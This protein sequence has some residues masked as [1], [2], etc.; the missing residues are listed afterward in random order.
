MDFEARDKL[1]AALLDMV[2]SAMH[3]RPS[4]SKGDL[5]N[6]WNASV[7]ERYTARKT[8]R[9]REEASQDP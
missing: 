4:P 9:K 7:D 6:V 5:K 2:G 1:K 3:K 8:I